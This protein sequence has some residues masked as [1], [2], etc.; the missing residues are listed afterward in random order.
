MQKLRVRVLEFVYQY[1][2]QHVFPPLGTHR[3]QLI[4]VDF[5]PAE[6]A[7]ARSS[8]ISDDSRQLL[9]TIE[10]MRVRRQWHLWSVEAPPVQVEPPPATNEDA[11]MI[12]SASAH[13][14][15]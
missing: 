10:H 4:V 11:E 8:L 2:F 12:V 9:F 13:A 6:S 5:T 15:Q 7:H 1:I 14:G 3:K